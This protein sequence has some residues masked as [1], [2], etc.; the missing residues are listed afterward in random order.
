M[1]DASYSHFAANVAKDAGDFG[2]F[3][4]NFEYADIGEDD[5]LG[6]AS[7]DDLKTWVGWSKGF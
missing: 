6:T 2:E 5:A 4:I 1:G 3:S 7:S